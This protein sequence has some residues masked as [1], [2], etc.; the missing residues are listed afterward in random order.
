MPRE[1]DGMRLPLQGQEPLLWPTRE[2][3]YCNLYW[4]TASGY[5]VVSG[6]FIVNYWS[7][8]TMSLVKSVLDRTYSSP[9]LVRAAFNSTFLSYLR[10]FLF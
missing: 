3:G 10:F 6:M 9:S 2:A 4:E 8:Y 1:K 5:S 7:C